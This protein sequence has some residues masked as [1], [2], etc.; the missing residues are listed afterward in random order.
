[1]FSFTL[2]VA[3]LAINAL[4]VPLN[5]LTKRQGGCKKVHF[6]FARG[7]TEGGTMGGTVGPA[8]SRALATKFGAGNVA[9]EGVRYPA[10][11]AGAFSGGTNPGGAKG[12]INMAAM[13]KA[14]MNKCPTTRIVLGGYSQGAE[15]VHGALASKN[16]GQDGARI[17][18][19]FFS[20]RFSFFFLCRFFL[21]FFL[22]DISL[23]LS[24][25]YFSYFLVYIF[26]SS[27][28]FNS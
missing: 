10:D 17:A 22:V 4:A 6:I 23:F 11:I 13:A 12:S 5:D 7:S 25:R 18:V 9:S 14:V 21:S 19:S 28:P 24:C 2:L 15:Q 16:L 3:Y 1:M 20:C 26:L 8:F 27:F